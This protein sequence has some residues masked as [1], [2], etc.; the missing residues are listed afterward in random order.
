M[1]SEGHV[2]VL[3]FLKI[4]HNNHSMIRLLEMITSV[5][6]ETQEIARMMFYLTATLLGARVGCSGGSSCCQFNNPPWFCKTLPQSTD[7]LEI[8]ICNT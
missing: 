6:L 7:D 2:T 3:A 5:I 8:R 1:S 4:G